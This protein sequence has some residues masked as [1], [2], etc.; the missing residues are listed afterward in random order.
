MKRMP[1]PEQFCIVLYIESNK[2]LGIEVKAQKTIL[3]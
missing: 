2:L 3:K 1:Y